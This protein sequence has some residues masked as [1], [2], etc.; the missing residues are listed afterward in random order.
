MRLLCCDQHCTKKAEKELQEHVPS[1][2]SVAE[3]GFLV[4]FKRFFYTNLCSVLRDLFLVISHMFNGNVT[5]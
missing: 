1:L 4:L 2:N 3:K 5:D